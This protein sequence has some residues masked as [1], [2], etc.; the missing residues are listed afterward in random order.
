MFAEI[1]SVSS[2]GGGYEIFIYSRHGTVLDYQGKDS[3]LNWHD[4][5]RHGGTSYGGGQWI[6]KTAIS[7]YKKA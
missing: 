4:F 1:I 7:Y 5:V 3:G 2:C 6:P